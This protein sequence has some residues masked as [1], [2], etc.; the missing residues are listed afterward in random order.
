MSL[1][2]YPLSPAS[3]SGELSALPSQGQAAGPLDRHATPPL[4]IEIGFL[5]GHGVS[6]G[7]LY[8]AAFLAVI[9]GVHA[10]EVLI[11]HGFVSENVFYRALARELDV[12]FARRPRLGRSAHYPNSILAGLVPH[13]DGGRFVAAPQGARIARLLASRRLRESPLVITTPTALAAAVF[14][15]RGRTIAYRAAYDL[16]DQAPNLSIS[17]GAY[18][19][20]FV[21]ALGLVAALSFVLTLAP[22]TALPLLGTVLGVVFLAMVL[23]RLSPVLRYNPIE[24]AGPLLRAPDA[25]LPVYTVI[26]ALHRER[27]V[28]AQLV[29]ALEALDYPRTKLDIKL[30]LEAHDAETRLALSL[31]DLPP[32]WRCS[33][34]HRACR[35]RSRAPSTSG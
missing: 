13:A 26:V 35:A 33:S 16:P 25:A 27:R 15:S 5:T 6:A 19:R 8:H 22:G 28:V 23:L 29:A 14:R 7:T 3:P 4:P 12:P 11:R 9:A 17:R 20:Q 24:P 10:D 32:S 18:M 21:G 1:N 31:L 34:F 30:V 2:P